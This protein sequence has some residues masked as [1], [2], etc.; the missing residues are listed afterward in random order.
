MKSGIALFGDFSM[1]VYDM[2][3]GERQLV[4]RFQK[5]NQITNNGRD[6][7]LRLL[8][9]EGAPH[10]VEDYQLG[11]LTVGTNNATPTVN[12]TLATI[13][14]VWTD[15]FEL[16]ECEVVSGASE[17]FYIQISKSMP[18]E[19]G[20]GDEICEAGVLTKGDI[21]YARQVFS[22]IVKTATM[23]IQFDWQLGVTI[24]GSV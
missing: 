1:R 10:L 17:G 16:E 12:D 3:D 9:P 24:Q 23:S 7:I 2:V 21:L 13:N 4:L 22:P 8:R 14:S 5:R 18:M 15:S 19:E 6:V 11:K 20:V